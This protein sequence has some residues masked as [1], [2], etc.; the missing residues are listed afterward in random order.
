MCLQW[1][2]VFGYFWLSSDRKCS[3]LERSST[4][5]NQTP[6]PKNA[7]FLCLHVRTLPCA[8]LKRF[9]PLLIWLK[10]VSST[11]TKTWCI[12]NCASHNFHGWFKGLKLALTKTTGCMLWSR[13]ATM[14]EELNGQALV[15]HLFQLFKL[16][17]H[18][19]CLLLFTIC[20]KSHHRGLASKRE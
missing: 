18:S 14:L 6:C 20:F 2:Y 12:C 17:S 8:M 3:V 19:I 7:Q 11:C 1:A 16:I 15:L 5:S 4:P 13:P 10:F 9:E